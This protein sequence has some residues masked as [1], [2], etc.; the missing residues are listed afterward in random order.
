MEIQNLWP[1]TWIKWKHKARVLL[2]PQDPYLQLWPELVGNRQHNTMLPAT[3]RKQIVWG[4]NHHN[5]EPGND[6]NRFSR[7]VCSLRVALLRMNHCQSWLPRS[8]WV[9]HS[10]KQSPLPFYWSLLSM[11][12]FLKTILRLFIGQRGKDLAKFQRYGGY[13]WFLNNI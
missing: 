1:L 4:N 13:H 3:V 12:K 7:G 11:N 5:P 9:T 10:C 6:W 8:H 2:Q